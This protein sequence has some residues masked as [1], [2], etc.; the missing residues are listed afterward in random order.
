V[1]DE[2]HEVDI[3]TWRNQYPARMYPGG[4]Q[5]DPEAIATP[6]ERLLSWWNPVSWIRAGLRARRADLVV[7]P[8]VVPVHAATQLTVWALARRKIV[9]HVH[10]PVPHEPFPGARLIARLVLGRARVLVCHAESIAAE[11]RKLGI[12]RRCVVVPHP[13]DVDIVPAPPPPQPQPTKLLLLGHLRPYK[14]TD[15]ALDAMK[16]LRERGETMTM[17]IAG[18]PWGDVD[19]R[20]EISQRGLT[21]VVDLE[22]RYVDDAELGHL[23]AAHH[24]LV[25]PYRNATQSGVVALAMAANRPVVAS[26]VGGLRD[27]VEDGTT[28]VLVSPEDPSALAEGLRRAIDDYEQLVTNV[29]LVD[30]R[31]SDVAQAILDG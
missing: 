29:R 30:H 6:A 25:A 28:G 2:G 21:D 16:Q 7:M 12:R 24:L 5:V 8:W 20:A 18:Q 23:L 15:I 1:A 10:N 22:L 27:L 26:D 19:W 3:V 11:V 9:F 14:G 31:W 17:T 4:D 13:P